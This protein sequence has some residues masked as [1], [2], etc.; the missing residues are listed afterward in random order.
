MR[1]KAKNEQYWVLG[2]ESVVVYVDCYT[3]VE[4]MKVGESALRMAMKALTV[5]ATRE[6]AA[7]EMTIHGRRGGWEKQ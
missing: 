2:Y 6:P 3:K 4:A 5:N 7:Y 1:R